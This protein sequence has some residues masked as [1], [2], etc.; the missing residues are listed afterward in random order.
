MLSSVVVLGLRRDVVEYAGNL[1]ERAFLLLTMSVFLEYIKS[2]LEIFRNL[3]KR[4]SQVL[5]D[6]SVESTVRRIHAIRECFLDFYL[7]PV[8][9]RENQ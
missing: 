3:C 1:P 4:R 2:V 7:I 8:K 6:S 5:F 9:E